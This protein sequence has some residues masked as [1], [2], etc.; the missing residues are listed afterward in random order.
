M[1]IEGVGDVDLIAKSSL[2]IRKSKQLKPNSIKPST[3]VF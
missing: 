3:N 2:L 1:K